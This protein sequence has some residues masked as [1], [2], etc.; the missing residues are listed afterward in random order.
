MK[1]SDLTSTFVHSKTGGNRVRVVS[2]IAGSNNRRG[3]G[4]LTVE[5]GV[6]LLDLVKSDPGGPKALNMAIHIEE[7]AESLVCFGGGDVGHVYKRTILVLVALNSIV[8]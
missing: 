1:S 6:E 3:R 2:F 5:Q 8:V 4:G 7:G